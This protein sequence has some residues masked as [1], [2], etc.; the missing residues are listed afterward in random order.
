MAAAALHSNPHFVHVGVRCRRTTL[1]YLPLWTLATIKVIPCLSLIPMH[2]L[3]VG[4]C[5]GPSSSLLCLVEV[6]S[7]SANHSG[8]QAGQTAAVMESAEALQKGAVYA[9]VAEGGKHS[10]T[11]HGYLPVVPKSPH[12][13]EEAI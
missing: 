1:V 13:H 8:L 3:P 2:G 10:R 6:F 7:E 11:L 12:S 9:D 5:L 4:L